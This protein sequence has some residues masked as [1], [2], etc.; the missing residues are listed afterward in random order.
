VNEWPA[1]VAEVCNGADD[2]CD[3][4]ADEDFPL[5]GVP[6]DGPDSDF[7]ARGTWTCRADGAAVECVNEWPANVA[8]VCNGADDD[9]DGGVDEDFPAKGQACDSADSDSCA[10]GSWTCRADGAGVE[11]VNEWPANVAEVCNGTDDDCDGQLDE[12]VCPCQWKNNGHGYLFCTHAKTWDQ[13]RWTCQT[14]G[15]HMVAI[16]SQAENTWV[17]DTA[18][19]IAAG[20]TWW[21]GGT[22][23]GHEGWW[24]WEDGEGW[25][26]SN[27]QAGEPNNANGVENC[28]ELR[29]F[30]NRKWNDIPCWA[31]NYY[32][33]EQ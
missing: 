21:T 7:C 17:N 1:N 25:P 16:T 18:A 6:C 24:T 28:L 31:G 20:A 13:A 5:K 8:E 33:C 19:A 27:W 15:L 29:R 11:C 26:Y 23:A 2:D 14:H 12:N 4:K 32:V 30:G 9:C 10:Y 22:D 3:G